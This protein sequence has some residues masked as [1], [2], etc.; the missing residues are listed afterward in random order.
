[1]P[2]LRTTKLPPPPELSDKPVW[3]YV[4]R[5]SKRR[6]LF[7][8]LALVGVLYL[9]RGGGSFGGLVDSLAP[10]HAAAPGPAADAPVFHL[11]VALPPAKPDR[12]DKKAPKDQP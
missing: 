8:L 5:K 3:H 11:R 2:L 7:L 9:R 10:S 12:T 6:A 1:M 4:S